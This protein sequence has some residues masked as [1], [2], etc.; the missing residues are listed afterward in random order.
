MGLAAGR[1]DFRN[2]LNDAGDA[3]TYANAP[4]ATVRILRASNG[5]PRVVYVDETEGV[6]EVMLYR[7]VEELTPEDYA[8]Y[9]I[10]S[11]SSTL[12]D[13]QQLQGPLARY[14]L[15]VAFGAPFDDQFQLGNDAYYSA[16]LIYEAAM[17]AGVK[18]AEPVTLASLAAAD[19]ELGD[20]VLTAAHASQDCASAQCVSLSR[21][22]R[23][24]ECAAALGCADAGFSRIGGPIA[25]RCEVGFLVER[26][27]AC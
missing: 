18:L 13:G 12:A 17:S 2:G 20:R 16:E 26:S 9:R 3:E 22:D 11:L 25:W 8:V 7:F 27:V 23:H 15:N 5:G 10:E 21:R 1:S 19:T 14:A 24:G 4:W 6:T